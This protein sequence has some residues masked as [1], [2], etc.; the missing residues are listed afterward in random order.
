MMAD[1]RLGKC[2]ECAKK[3]VRDNRR[4]R[5]DY[6]VSYDRERAMLPHRVSARQHYIRTPL[7]K[8]ALRRAHAKYRHEYPER[9]KA[10]NI[11]SNA[12]RDGKIKRADACWCCGSQNRIH[13]HHPDYS[14]PLDVVWLCNTCHVE[15]HRA[16]VE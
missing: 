16:S 7:G 12:I 15:A 8:E 9:T 1:G 4:A 14:R 10:R 5:L 3:D 6:Y 13:G 11:L 2:K